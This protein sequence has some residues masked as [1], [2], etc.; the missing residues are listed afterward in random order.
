M[1]REELSLFCSKLSLKTQDRKNGMR[2]EL[3]LQSNFAYFTLKSMPL[4][5]KGVML[6]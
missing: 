2:S 4:F 6:T 3:V 5:I 1:I